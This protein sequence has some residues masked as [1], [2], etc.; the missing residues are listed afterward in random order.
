MMCPVLISSD[1]RAELIW[2][3][4][5]YDCRGLGANAMRTEGARR[6][7]HLQN[8]TDHEKSGSGMECFFLTKKNWIGS[9]LRHNASPKF[10][11]LN[12]TQ[13]QLS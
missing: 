8:S 1:K 9:S 12:D 7:H 3:D 11:E 5:N 13:M 6:I 4:Q 10:Q 2:A